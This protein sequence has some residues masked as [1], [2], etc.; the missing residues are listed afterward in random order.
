MK[1][2]KKRIRLT[3]DKP[4]SK[5]LMF[6]LVHNNCFAKDG[7]V[8]FR[9]YESEAPARAYIRQLVKYHLDVDLPEDEAE[10]DQD[11]IDALSEP[12]SDMLTPY[13]YLYWTMVACSDMRTALKHY[14]DNDP[15]TIDYQ[16]YI[17]GRELT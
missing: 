8:H 16:A 2:F 3:T 10:F 13:V 14:E 4:V 7:E 17:T 1:N 15:E 6:E 11:M 5:M 9:T 12:D